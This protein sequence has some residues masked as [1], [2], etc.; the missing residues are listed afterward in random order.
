MG[1]WDAFNRRA[2]S[3]ETRCLGHWDTAMMLVKSALQRASSTCARVAFQLCN[4]D[5]QSHFW[6]IEVQ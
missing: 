2:S 5:H 6:S 1:N 4:D 3:L